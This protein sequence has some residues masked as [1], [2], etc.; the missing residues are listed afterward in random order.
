MSIFC[1]KKIQ[2]PTAVAQE[3]KTARQQLGLSLFDLEKKT[4]IDKKYLLAIEKNKLENLPEAKVLKTAYI[5]KYAQTVGL[6]P[7]KI[8]R[9][10]CYEADL[11]NCQINHPNKKLKKE[12]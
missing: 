2:K 3:L 11:N 6:D 9:H 8:C 5:K 12:A 4:K 1:L 7:E 10:F